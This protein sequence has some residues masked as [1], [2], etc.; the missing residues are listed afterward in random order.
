MN[1]PGLQLPL[2]FL[3]LPGHPAVPWG[4]WKQAFETNMVTSGASELPAGRCKAIRLTC[5]G[6]ERQQISSLKPVALPSGSTTIATTRPSS[7]GTTVMG[8]DAIVA[9]QMQIEGTP[10]QHLPLTSSPHNYSTENEAADMLSA[11]GQRLYMSPEAY[12][13]SKNRGVSEL[14]AEPVQW[15]RLAV[16]RGS[17]HPSSSLTGAE[18]T[19]D[20]CDFTQLVHL[21]KKEMNLSPKH[22]SYTAT[23]TSNSQQMK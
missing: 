14:H 6:M 12:V 4:Q 9:L 20:S 2:L 1:I 21:K 11:S 7:E 13:L 3:P 8:L 22:I 17:G 19:A 5:L 10:L 18:M 23:I 16:G 15:K